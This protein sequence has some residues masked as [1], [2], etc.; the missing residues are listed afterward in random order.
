MLLNTVLNDSLQPI[1]G[2][3]I[4][5][6][7]IKDNTF[8][9][10]H[11]LESS[12][13]MFLHAGGND[14]GVN[15]IKLISNCTQLIIL[16]LSYTENLCI[17]SVIGMICPQLIRL[18]LDGCSLQST[19]LP[20]PE[21]HSNDETSSIFYGLVQLKELSLKENLFKD[22]ESLKGLSFFSF[23]NKYTDILVP[24]LTTVSLVDNPLME[25]TSTRKDMETF[26][27]KELPFLTHLND[28]SMDSYIG[29]SGIAIPSGDLSKILKR[30][31][32]GGS[33]AVGGQ[34]GFENMD[35]EYL[36]ALKG[37]RDV[38]IVS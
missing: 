14:P 16:D 22:V 6:N 36:A 7:G 19:L 3:N 29:A 9:C 1:K 21:D 27:F 13:L 18:V 15:F 30:D 11:M 23:Q 35:K 38:T 25:V 37:E 31:G 2:L 10:L 24:T 33:V 5:N 28:K 17:S 32:G 26:I 20:T 4:A 34:E 8:A 12:Y